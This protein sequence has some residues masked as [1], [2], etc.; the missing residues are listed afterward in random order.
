[1]AFCHLLAGTIHARAPYISPTMTVKAAPVEEPIRVHCL[2]FGRY[3]ELLEVDRLSLAM[4]AA[5][6]AD[7]AVAKLRAELPNGAQVPAA[8]MVAI[9]RRHVMLDAT[10]TDGDE[11]ALLPPLAGG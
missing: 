7:D 4:P 10:L 3:A 11:L 6:T 8:P 5:A 2:L 1:M 9:N